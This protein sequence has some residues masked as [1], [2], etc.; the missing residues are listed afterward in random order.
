[1][2]LFRSKLNRIHLISIQHAIHIPL[3]IL[4]LI[5]LES[6]FFNQSWLQ[7]LGFHAKA[8]SNQKF[9]EV[10]TLGTEDDDVIRERNQIKETNPYSDS[11]VRL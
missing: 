2:V 7:F 1:M 5:Y 10:R 8:S 11:T 3:L 6:R 4:L 9:Q